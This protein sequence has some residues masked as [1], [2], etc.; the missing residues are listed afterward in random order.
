M[1]IHTKNK[2]LVPNNYMEYKVFI[3]YNYFMFGK[4]V[5]MADSWSKK[6][7]AKRLKEMRDDLNMT[8]ECFAEIIDISIQTYKNMERG[9]SNISIN[10]LK[11]MK[12]KLNFSTDYLLF[13][14]ES[15]LNSVWNDVLA[16]NGIEKQILLIRLLKEVTSR[17]SRVATK[18]ND[19]NYLILLG[20]LME[21]MDS[22]E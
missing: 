8:Q 17:N 13:D 22:K 11:K 2:P 7:V 4:G 19:D 21:I 18:E 14:E 6:E 3:P 1:N 9:Q 5:I 12:K 10:T 16:L 15:N 20:K